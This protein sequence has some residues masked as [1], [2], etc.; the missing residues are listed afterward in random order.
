MTA[1]QIEQRLQDNYDSVN[2]EFVKMVEE[3]QDEMLVFLRSAINRFKY[4]GEEVTDSEENMVAISAIMS[5]LAIRLS[6]SRYADALRYFNNMMREQ[7]SLTRDYFEA[8]GAE[9]SPEQFESI[10]SQ[11]NNLLR[12]AIESMTQVDASFYSP[13]R[14]ALL[15]AVVGRSTRNILE[16]SVSEIVVGNT[17]KKG[18][19]YVFSNTL[20]D[21][22]FASIGRSVTMSMARFA[23]FKRYR[24]S[25]GL[26]KDS[27]DFCI[28]RD[29]GVFDE[30]TIRSWAR[31]DWQGKIPN[32]TEN[33]IFYYLGGYRCRHWLVPV[34]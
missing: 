14:N 2:E 5:E 10:T 23:G 25:G 1:E 33:T 17:A 9:I 3:A 13:I 30:K 4:E 22:L 32:T 18:R 24:Y 6:R 11:E 29:G 27:R 20:S 26:I 21:T 28:A 15:L 19:L 16:Q 7:F 8:I 34:R 31:L 12:S